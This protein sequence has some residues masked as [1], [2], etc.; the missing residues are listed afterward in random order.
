MRMMS[1]E[2]RQVGDRF[3]K[4]REEMGLTLKE[5]EASTSIRSSFLE[6]IEEGRIRECIAEVY[7]VGFMRQYGQ[8]LDLKIEILSRDFPRVFALKRKPHTFSYG[9]GTL[10]IRGS[11]G[12]GIKWLPGVLWATGVVLL[13][14]FAYYLARATGVVG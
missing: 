5:C 1:S 6:A 8:F 3:R 10:E 7:A 2:S 14:V 9:I 11:L 12:G 4:R 13:V